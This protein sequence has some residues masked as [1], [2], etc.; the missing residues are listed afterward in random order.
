MPRGETKHLK[1]H[2]FKPGQTGNPSGR[3]PNPIKNALK[4]LTGQSLQRIIKAVVKGNIDEVQRIAQDPN[5]SGIEVAV[6]AC[7]IKAVKQGD[8]STV[9]R[10]IERIVG[11]IPDKLL[12]ES[13]S[14]TTIDATIK[15]VPREIAI[16]A[17]REIEDEC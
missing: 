9:E 13:T 12:V 4:K 2:Q 14:T 1:P 6:A 5:S 8:W 15:V 3:P 16:Q 11:K 17:F 7:F 10:M